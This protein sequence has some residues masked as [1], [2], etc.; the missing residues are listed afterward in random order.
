MKNVLVPKQFLFRLTFINILVI[1]A[2]V[3][4]SSWAIYNTACVLAGGIVAMSNPKQ[5]QFEATLLQ[6]LWIFSISTII[7]GSLTHFYLTKKLIHPLR[8]L[9]YSTKKMKHGEYPKPITVKS[10]G[11]IAELVHHFND[12]VKQLEENEKQRRKLVSDLSH[13]FRTPLSNLNGYLRALQSGVVKGDEKLYQSLY[14]ESKR[15]IQLVEQ[16]EQLKEWDYVSTLTFS[17]KEPIEIN[18]LVDQS[19]EMFRWSMEQYNIDV[20]VAVEPNLVMVNSGAITQ[21][22]SN[23]L[24]N[25]IRYYEG[26]GPITITG[27]NHQSVY[28]LSVTGPSKP[29]SLEEQV[30][31]FE[32][33]YRID[34]SRSKELGGSGL[35][36]AISKEIIEHHHGKIGLTSNGNVHR[37]WFQIPRCGGAKK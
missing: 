10:D 24:D 4:L 36:L 25:A 12:L 1:T 11:E 14:G 17:K 34:H 15:L 9:I 16:M 3:G 23:L 32:R 21:V 27:E 19:V 30:K 7:I 37:F 18:K 13:E 29:I 31:V 22:I 28:I 8:E 26:T 5:A 20:E 6:Y 33:F 35:G 2:F